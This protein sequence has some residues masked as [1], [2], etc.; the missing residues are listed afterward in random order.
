MYADIGATAGYGVHMATHMAIGWVCLGG[1]RYTFDQAQWMGRSPGGFV[2][3]GSYRGYPPSQS[4]I[5][6]GTSIFWWFVDQQKC[7][8][9][10]I[11]VGLEMVWNGDWM[12]NA[13][14]YIDIAM[15]NQ[16][17]KKL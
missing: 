8:L 5:F 15:E 4:F 16:H 9:N 17:V 2:K 12:G 7:C 3:W 11:F 14:L 13:L 10:G 6:M 1:G